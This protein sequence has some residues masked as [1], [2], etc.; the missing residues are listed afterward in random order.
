MH[1]RERQSSSSRALFGIGISIAFHFFIFV[2]FAF[3]TPF[4]ENKK[5][6]QPHTSKASK[7]LRVRM[8][9]EITKKKK[10][11]DP[12]KEENLQVVSAPK[13][14][15]E[16]T[17]DEAKFVDRYQSKVKKQSVKKGKEGSPVIANRSENAP[18][19][20]APFQKKGK[21][22]KANI[23]EKKKFIDAS[24]KSVEGTRP[25]KKQD[26]VILNKRADTEKGNS[27]LSS[28]SLFPQ[29][30]NTQS[31]NPLGVSGSKD[32]LRDVEEGEK[33]LLNRKRT[34]YWAFFNRVKTQIQRQWNP[35][36]EY[37][38]RDP[39]GDVY[40]VRDRYSMINVILNSDG[41]IRRLYVERDSGIEFLDEEAMR[42]IRKGAPYH[43]PPE[44][45]KDEDG[46]IH[47]KF[48]FFFEIGTGRVNFFKSFN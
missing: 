29:L 47:F 3:F 36:K 6:H 24:S 43:A 22:K 48:G 25:Q 10:K 4:S 2:I 20:T 1:F 39:Y 27:K 9:S 30:S 45:L 12:V 7:T 28:K 23:V 19:T 40:G 46:N 15:K 38:Q 37:R 41:T 32:Y 16:E 11:K 33:T 26:G 17:P 34:R 21:E 13:P 14:E 44:G 5:A 18:K 8:V 35:V 31:L 42:A